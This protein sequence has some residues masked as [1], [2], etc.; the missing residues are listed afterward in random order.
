MNLSRRTFLRAAGVSLSL[1]LLEAMRP[2][3]GAESPAG[4][5]DETPR[6]MVAV[7]TNLGV[8][9]RHFVPKKAGAGYELTPYLQTLSDLRDQFTV[10]TGSSHP[11]VNGGHS[12]EAAFLTAAP[13]PG[14]ASFRN[15]ISLDQYAAERIGLRTR[16][17]SLSLVVAQNGNQSL[18]FTSDGVMLPAERSPAQVFRTLFVEGD[19]ATVERQVE[20]LRVGRSILDTVGERA[21]SLQKS[22]GNA[23]RDRLDQYFSSVREV[24][25]RLQTAQEWE[26]KPKP[27]VDAPPPRDGE[28]LLE[29]LG[30]MYDLI[31][32]AL[33]TDSTRIVT[34]MVR[35][36]G[37]GAQVPGVSDESHNLS[38][39]VGRPDKLDQ[40]RNF[41]LAQFVELAK[42]LKGL[43]AAKESGASLLDR[44][45]VLYGSNLG[46]GNNHD[47]KNLPIVLAG[48]GF[49]HGQHLAFD[50]EN[51]Y[52]LPNLF[53]SML[54]RLGIESDKFAGATGTMRGL[55]TK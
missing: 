20:Q 29:K 55:E 33:P 17:S 35:T 1:P 27:K 21:K 2:A 15:T 24:E 40:L 42:L 47:N 52:P 54:Q 12:T 51:N 19:K 4:K 37:F 9:E 16:F 13:H 26:K 34:L 28:H 22:V 14:A 25:R 53:V 50:K 5:A 49:K 23:D 10:I 3:A 46:N 31:R 8:L 44:T 6:R 38:H 18:S 41:E 43:G 39:H 48:G 7:C 32:L 45:S 11:D 30:A 36:D